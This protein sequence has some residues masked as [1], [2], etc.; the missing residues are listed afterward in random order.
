MERKPAKMIGKPAKKRRW[1]SSRQ[2][3]R[4]YVQ[5]LHRGRSLWASVHENAKP[6]RKHG[7][8]VDEELVRG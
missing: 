7:G 3:P 6:N 5:K 2:D 1:T 4:G 8:L